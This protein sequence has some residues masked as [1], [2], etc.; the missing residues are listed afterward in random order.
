[1]NQKKKGRPRTFDAEQVLQRAAMLFAR[2]GFSA[3]SL[4]ELSEA[5]GL[6]RPSLYNA[7]GDK[8]SLYRKVLAYHLRETHA[9]L[10]RELCSAA[11]L[12][13]E[14]ERMFD[15][16][17]DFCRTGGGWLTPCTAPA[18]ADNHPEIAEDVRI[19]LAA[20]DQLL[21]A[22]FAKARKGELRN[23]VSPA[24]AAEIA[25]SVLHSIALRTR[26][27]V[28]EAELRALGQAAVTVLVDR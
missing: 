1:M 26:A 12:R 6:V 16:M 27:G 4:D 20:F 22:R 21:Q 18:E 17:I 2:K 25:Q 23:H 14:L 11:D 5:T 7:F 15:A 3:T 24:M 8:L 9:I 28:E 19:M 13:V 10:G